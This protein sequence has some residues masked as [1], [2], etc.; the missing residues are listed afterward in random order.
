MRAIVADDELMVRRGIIDSVDWD[1]FGIDEVLEAKNGEI[2]LE[3]MKERP[4]DIL[5][6]DIRMP[7]LDGI[8]LGKKVS[9]IYP[10]CRIIFISAYTDKEYFKNAIS[11]NVVAYVEKPISIEEI[12]AAIGKASEMARQNCNGNEISLLTRAFR[13]LLFECPVPKECKQVI[14]KYEDRSYCVSLIRVKMKD[15]D[16]QDINPEHIRDSF[17][18]YD[19][20]CYL[21]GDVFR[22]EYV[23]IAEKKGTGDI[24]AYCAE[25]LK[26]YS[27]VYMN[28]QMFASIG[29]TVKGIN[30]IYQ[31]IICA[32]EGI[33]SLFLKDMEK[34]YTL[35]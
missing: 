25:A 34:P 4:A 21:F 6:A 24:S 31:S 30:N 23:I 9:E 18:R 13:A 1:A 11:L 33:N 19:L 16:C 7:R 35:I 27:G 14:K 8:Q 2:C 20:K 17:C 28:N 12:S 29:K 26:A 32:Q 3:T 22:K 15:L 5:I 10:D